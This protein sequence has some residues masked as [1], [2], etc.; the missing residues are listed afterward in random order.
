MRTRQF[1]LTGLM[2]LLMHKDSIDGGDEL[3]GWRKD[4]ANKNLSTPGD[5]RSPAWTWQTYLYHDGEH[6]AMESQNIMVCIRQAAVNIILKRQKTFKELSQSGMLIPTEFCQ[7]SI[8]GAQIP[9]GPITAMRGDDFKT[10]AD[11]V[12]KMGFRLFCKRARVG[13]AKH[14]R[15]RARFDRWEITGELNIFAKEITDP[16]LTEMLAMAGRV[17]LCDWRPGCKTP[18]PF[19]MFEAKLI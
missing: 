14:V 18:G 12:R 7:F 4:P 15:V 5:D 8:G 6:L 10:Q 19:G 11:K 13:Q 2:P 3:Q 16:I 9:M 17:G 1:Q